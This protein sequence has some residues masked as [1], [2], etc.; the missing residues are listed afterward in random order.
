MGGPTGRKAIGR[1]AALGLLDAAK[2]VEKL[3][4]RQLACLELLHQ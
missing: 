1:S 2:L 3:L 4:F